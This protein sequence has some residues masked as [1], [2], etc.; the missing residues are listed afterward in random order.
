MNILCFL[1]DPILANT[2]N[3]RKIEVQDLN[4]TFIVNTITSNGSGNDRNP[5][6]D[7]IV[8][9]IGGRPTEKPPQLDPPDHCESCS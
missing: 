6:S 8:G 7:W 5:I 9:I 3:D 1:K 4:D 2:T